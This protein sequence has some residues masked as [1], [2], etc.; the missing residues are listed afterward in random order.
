[1]FQAIRVVYFLLLVVLSGVFWYE[2]EQDYKKYS[3]LLGSESFSG[4]TNDSLVKAQRL[5]NKRNETT[6]IYLSFLIPAIVLAFW[7]YKKPSR[8][9]FIV[10]STA[11][12]L[13]MMG[14]LFYL[15]HVA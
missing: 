1:M 8:F 7:F 3:F 11:T 5:A 4:K 15:L 9:S 10:F 12:G 2:S 13:A 6:R 14:L